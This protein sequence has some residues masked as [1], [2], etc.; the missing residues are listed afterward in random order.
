MADDSEQSLISP[1]EER[2]AKISH[3]GPWE[4]GKVIGKGSSGIV[5]L[6]EHKVT[7]QKAAIKV[8]ST[9][10]ILNSRMS[11]SVEPEEADRI[12]QSIEREIVIMKL[13]EHPNVLSLL[14]VWEAKGLLFVVMEYIDGGELFDYLVERGRLPVPEALHYFQQIMYAVAYC[15][16]FQIAHRDLKPEN[17]LLDKDKNIKVAD[18][19][20]AAFVPHDSLLYTSCGSPHYASPEVVSGLAYSGNMSDIWSCGVILYALLAG[21]LPFDDED[22]RGLLDKVREGKYSIPTDIPWPA[23]N[24]IRRMM[25]KDVERRIEVCEILTHP[26]FRSV[27]PR[28]LP[29]LAPSF[30]DLAGAVPPGYGSGS[31]DEDIIKN[32]RTLW[33]NRQDK[34]IVRALRN[35]SDNW[36]KI[37]YHLLYEFRMKRLRCIGPDDSRAQRRGS[38]RRGSRAHQTDTLRITSS[39]KRVDSRIFE[40]PPAP[41][42]TRSRSQTIAVNISAS[43]NNHPVTNAIAPLTPRKRT[44]TVPASSDSDIPEIVIHN[45]TPGKKGSRLSVDSLIDYGDNT[46]TLFTYLDPSACSNT[47]NMTGVDPLVPLGSLDMQEDVFFQQI[48][49]MLVTMS[50]QEEAEGKGSGR[51]RLNG[52]KNPQELKAPASEVPPPPTTPTTPSFE[53][54]DTF[55]PA[56]RLVQPTIRVVPPAGILLPSNTDKSAQHSK[57]GSAQPQRSLKDRVVPPKSI[58]IKPTQAKENTPLI[59]AESAPPPRGRARAMTV[60]ATSER[61]QQQDPPKKRVHIVTPDPSVFER[62]RKRSQS[63]S[64]DESRSSENWFANFFHFKPNRQEL[65]SVHD[66]F[67]TRER[68]IASLRTLGAHVETG[69]PLPQMYGGGTLRCRVD[70]VVDPSGTATVSKPLRFRAEIRPTTGVR[71]AAGYLSEIVLIQEKG[72]PAGFNALCARLRRG[73]ELD[74]TCHP[75]GS[76]DV[77]TVT[78]DYGLPSP[79]LTVGGR[80]AEA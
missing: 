18:F 11:V 25:E 29:I 66:V 21:R 9:E 14:D 50:K 65:Y 10:A 1:I 61:S 37:A 55:A 15:H 19:G 68:C 77:L 27:P 39:P 60:S 16:R 5:H 71:Y 6:A 75:D 33:R 17:I 79:A 7:G 69:E 54:A 34:D 78:N 20:M 58:I 64:K 41:T 76:L 44:K 4:L 73:W 63:V 24:L 56:P 26:F 12:I 3:I 8:M 47:G 59:E 30:A 28:S 72:Q 31:I 49:E 80:Y 57:P 62:G 32:M 43:D 23:Q 51:P 42:P 46:G 52:T 22:I 40:R 36:E 13:I 48:A 53:E 70:E 74:V 2:V 38:K 67:L 45:A 35:K